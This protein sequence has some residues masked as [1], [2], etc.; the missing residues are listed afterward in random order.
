VSSPGSGEIATWTAPASRPM[1]KHRGCWSKT[2][3]TLI[4]SMEMAMVW[5]VR[6]YR[7]GSK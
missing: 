7:E 4:I 1:N 3:A 6:I 5:H 2:P